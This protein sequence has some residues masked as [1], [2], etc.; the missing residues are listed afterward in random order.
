MNNNMNNNMNDD[1]INDNEIDSELYQPLYM[2][3]MV[4]SYKL[5]TFKYCY[6]CNITE[7]PAWRRGPSGL[8]TLCNRCGLKYARRISENM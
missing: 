7:T 1:M 6:K 2:L 8:R 4:C 3:S 5:S